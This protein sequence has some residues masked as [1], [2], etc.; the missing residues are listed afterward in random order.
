M[1]ERES[2]FADALTLDFPEPEE[3]LLE[4]PGESCSWE[5]FM[6]ETAVQTNY[7]LKHFGDEDL[8]PP[9]EERFS[10]DCL[11]F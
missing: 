1:V 6:L 9:F 8:P 11:D 5:E 4:G 3:P 10:L 2:I 7:W